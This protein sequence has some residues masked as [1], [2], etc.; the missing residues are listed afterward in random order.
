MPDTPILSYK[1][2][3]SQAGTAISTPVLPSPPVSQL[4]PPKASSRKVLNRRKALQE[5]YNIQQQQEK[6]IESTGNHKPTEEEGAPTI[7]SSPKATLTDPDALAKF[8]KTSTIEDILRLRNSITNKLN[9]HDLA[10]KSIIYDN[11]YELI[12][13]SETLDTLTNPNEK[14]LAPADQPESIEAIF[15]DLHTFI[16]TE[17]AK[18]D[19]PFE[20]VVDTLKQDISELKVSDSTASI[21]GLRDEKQFPELDNEGLAREV[22]L[23]LDSDIKNERIVE[24]IQ[25]VLKELNVQKDGL[26]ILQLNEVKRKVIDAK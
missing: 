12:R 2:P 23:L 26:L 22:D 13:L 6:E 24:D 1:K 15:D 10:K 7:A 16:T 11:Y 8:T 18:F 25:K 9:S 3:S 21:V 14:S 17:S 19:A 4:S 20:T 5:F